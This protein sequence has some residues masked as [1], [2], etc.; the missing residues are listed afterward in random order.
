M[1]RGEKK[2]RDA[3]LIVVWVYEDGGIGMREE[4]TKDVCW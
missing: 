2:R 3:S 1:G 4:Q